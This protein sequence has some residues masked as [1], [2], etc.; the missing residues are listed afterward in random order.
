MGKKR[1]KSLS[2]RH[3]TN[4]MAK[5]LGDRKYH[6]RVV[7]DKREDVTTKQILKEISEERREVLERLAKR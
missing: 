2:S 3:K 7:P 6:Q 5:E 4:P 1:N